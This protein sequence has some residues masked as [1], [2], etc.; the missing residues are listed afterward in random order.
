[1]RRGPYDR[2]VPA[3]PVIDRQLTGL[4]KAMAQ[5]RRHRPRA[6]NL[7][8]DPWV[9]ILVAPMRVDTLARESEGGGGGLSARRPVIDRGPT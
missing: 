3:Q 7:S 2:L 9:D 5:D 6:I 1:M 8:Q 4:V